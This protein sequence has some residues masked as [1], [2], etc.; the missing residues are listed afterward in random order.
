MK[1]PFRVV[2]GQILQAAAFGRLCVETIAYIV[3][4]IDSSVAAFGRLCVETSLSR[5]ISASIKQPPSGGCVLKQKRP[6][7]AVIPTLQPP[8]GGCVLKPGGEGVDGVVRAA[9]A[10][11][12]LCVETL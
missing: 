3:T 5:K 8:S 2:I 9:A 7:R 12:R 11:G 4:I 10:F 1:R 6:G